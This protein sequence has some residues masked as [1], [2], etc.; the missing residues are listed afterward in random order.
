MTDM[1]GTIYYIQNLTNQKMYVGQ[2]WD[3]STRMLRHFNRL[4][5]GHHENLHLQEDWNRNPEEFGF[6]LLEWDIATQK[7]LNFMEDYWFDVTQCIDRRY[8]YNIRPAGSHGKFT[9]YA[10]LQNKRINRILRVETKSCVPKPW[11]GEEWK[12]S[13]PDKPSKNEPK[14]V[15]KYE[16]PKLITF[17]QFKRLI[18]NK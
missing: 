9:H 5:R 3:V 12:Y 15:A 11:E 13:E 6:G 18:E 14:N 17:A 4:R 2:T 8:G 7:E 10:L 1:S 16:P